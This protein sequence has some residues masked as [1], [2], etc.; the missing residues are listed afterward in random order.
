MEN[1]TTLNSMQILNNSVNSMPNLKLNIMSSVQIFQLYT[2]NA[3]PNSNELVSTCKHGIYNNNENPPNFVLT[4]DGQS[5]TNVQ[6]YISINIPRN[7]ASVVL[8]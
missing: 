3:M 2:T 5:N 8:S 6:N 1:A 4:R 7:S